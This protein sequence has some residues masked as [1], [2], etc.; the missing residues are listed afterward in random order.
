MSKSDLHASDDGLTLA[1]W[2]KSFRRI[3]TPFEQFLHRQTT[4]GL[5]LMGMAVLALV[6][7][8][9]P[10]AEAYDKIL[11]TYVGI[12]FGDWT[13]KMS[14]HHWINDALM[15]FFFFVVG[16]ELKREFLV[17]ELANPRNA[18]LPIAAAIG[19]RIR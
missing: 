5:L 1:P 10:F 12:G 18:A 14:L 15:A 19:S 7:A 4:S 8:N 6:L 16:L 13:L 2:E 3:V 17:G 9:G 11:K